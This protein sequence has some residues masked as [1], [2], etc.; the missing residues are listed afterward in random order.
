MSR[1]EIEQIGRGYGADLA[2][3]LGLA[4]DIS[5]KW[6]EFETKIE[7]AGEDI[8]TIL[9][10]GTGKLAKPLEHLSEGFEHQSR[11]CSATAAR[12]PD[13][14]KASEKDYKNSPTRL[15]AVRPSE[16]RH[17]SAVTSPRSRRTPRGHRCTVSA[18]ASGRFRNWCGWTVWRCGGG[19]YRRGSCGHSR[20]W[21]RGAGVGALGATVMPM[22]LNAG[23]DERARQQK[24]NQ[25]GKGPPMPPGVFPEKVLTKTGS[26]SDKSAIWLGRKGE[27][28]P[29]EVI[30]GT[31]RGVDKRLMDAVAAGAADLPPGYKVKIFSGYRQGDPGAH[32]RGQAIDVEIVDPHGNVIPSRGEDKTGMYRLLAK[33]TRD[34]MKAKYPDLAAH[35]LAWGGSFGTQKGGG[36]VS[37]LMHFDIMRRR[38]GVRASHYAQVQDLGPL[39]PLNERTLGAYIHPGNMHSPASRGAGHSHLFHRGD[40][41]ATMGRLPPHVEIEDNTGGMVSDRARRLEAR[42]TARTRVFHEPA[43]YYSAWITG[44]AEIFGPSAGEEI[45]K[46]AGGNLGIG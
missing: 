22:P 5:R 14:S 35:N 6:T 36:G 24:Y 16:R 25:G 19:W 23:E 27:P 8:D 2:T 46:G 3:R 43:S 32:G 7:K 1:G 34:E 13:G 33:A 45:S 4:P 18:G 17:S 11:L 28:T 26:L 37:D 15:V 21:H 20:P 42:D 29:L 31:T 44:N 40:H 41:P 30:H 39:P 10:K 9:W 38:G 12:Y